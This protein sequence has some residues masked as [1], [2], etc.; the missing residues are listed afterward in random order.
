LI[1]VFS[2]P[3]CTYSGQFVF[4]I[5]DTYGGGIAV[6]WVAIFETI[7]IMWVYGVQVPFYRGILTEGNTKGGSITVLLT[8]CLTRLD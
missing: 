5:M 8:S 2:L 4:D 6:F 3:V 7:V 1:F